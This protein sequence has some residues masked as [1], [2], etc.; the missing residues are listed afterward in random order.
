MVKLK[1]M[2]YKFRTLKKR[3]LTGLAY[4]SNKFHKE[5][6]KKTHLELKKTPYRF[7]V[8]N[9][10]LQ[11]FNRE[12]IYLEIGV[13][14][15]EDNFNKIIATNKYSVDPGVENILNPV[16][17]KVTSDD[18]FKQLNNGLVLNKDIKFDVIFIDGLHLAQ[19]VKKDID[20]S[21]KFLKEDG[22]IV[23]HD[24]NPPTEFHAS[25]SYLYRLSPSKD[26]W[27][28][29]TWKAFF[30]FRKREDYFSCCI[31][32]DWGIGI[33]SKN[34]NLGNK[35]VVENPFFEFKIFE[36]NRKESLNLISFEEFKKLI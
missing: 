36:K 1:K 6:I 8:L 23:L 17:Y 13:R 19:Q 34:I 25:E 9:Y 16:D 28:G 3:Y 14:N 12:T 31:D 11:N 29:T 21:L 22:F 5:G 27:N 32:S 33:I 18:F 2:R 4:L 30:N 20:N 24:C 15:P 10:I 35:S 26:Y 7:D